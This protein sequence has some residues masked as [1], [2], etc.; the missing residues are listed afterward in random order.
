M[1]NQLAAHMD[2]ASAEHR[3]IV[4]N[5]WQSPVIAESEGLKAVELFDAV[6]EGKIKAI[7]IMATN[8]VVSLPNADKVKQALMNCPLVIV[9]DCVEQTDTSKLAHI[10]FPALTWGERDGT[11]TNSERCISRQR[12]F[13]T[14]TRPGK[15]GLVDYY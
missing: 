15:A 5:F 14:N 1:A 11:V 7:W 13:F 4:Q 3:Q 8:P 12:P 10:N 2:I 6:S 9:S